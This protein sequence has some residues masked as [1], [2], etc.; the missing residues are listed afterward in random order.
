MH[1]MTTRMCIA[2]VGAVWFFDQLDIGALADHYNLPSHN[3]NATV[4]SIGDWN[5]LDSTVTDII[6]DDGVSQLGSAS[7]DL[8]PFS[9]LKRLEIGNYCFIH[10]RGLKLVGLSEL[11]SVVIGM[12][13]FVDEK[14]SYS[15]SSKSSFYLKNCPK[16]KSLKI[17]RYSFNDGAV[18]EIENVDAL[19]SIEIGDLNDES[20]NFGSTPLE[21][22]SILIHI[23]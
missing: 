21:L 15:G 10:V 3:P 20:G 22:R 12:N 23:K 7:M 16:L 14:N 1:F 4:L 2:R 17:G 9:Q 18:C 19:E 8:S 6:V 5:S 13:S 11:E